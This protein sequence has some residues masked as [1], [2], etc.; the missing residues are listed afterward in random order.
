MISTFILFFYLNQHQAHPL[1]L[2]IFQ[3]IHRRNNVIPPVCTITA[4][5]TADTAV[6]S[7]TVVPVVVNKREHKP[8]PTRDKNWDGIHN[9]RVHEY[10]RLTTF[11]GKNVCSDNETFEKWEALYSRQLRVFFNGIRFGGGRRR[12][13]LGWAH[14]LLWD[15][16]FSSTRKLCYTP[17]Q[18]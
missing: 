17:H 1:T 8:N 12:I 10:A 5:P 7:V 16:T 18:H 15:L 6:I 9:I 4:P 14:V 13:D 3:W 11:N 2:Q